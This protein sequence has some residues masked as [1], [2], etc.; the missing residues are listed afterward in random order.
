MANFNSQSQSRHAKT[1]RPMTREHLG[2]LSPQT[3]KIPGMK[4]VLTE[5][6]GKFGVASSAQDAHVA[7]LDY[8][9]GSGKTGMTY[10]SRLGNYVAEF[11]MSYFPY[12]K[13]RKWYVTPGQ[14]TFPANDPGKLHSAEKSRQCILCH[15]VAVPAKSLN[16]DERFLG[17]GCES[18]HGPGSAH[19]AAMRAGKP[20]AS[21]M[22]NIMSQTAT[23]INNLCGT[24]HG[25]E[26]EVKARHLESF[27]NRFQTY[28]LM[29]SE[30]FKQSK[31]TLS[32][33]T[34]HNPHQD[35]GTGHKPYE[36]VCLSCH[37]SPVST[38][39]PAPLKDVAIKPCP[40]NPKENCVSC[41]MPS[42]H[43]IANSKIPTQ[44]ADHFIRVIRDQ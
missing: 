37:A 9:F 28:G 11:H 3:G 44:M 40:V 4:L 34:C 42:R 35:A 39:R 33:V 6:K 1:L 10:V 31:D 16:L 14:E 2:K 30:C 41:H 20:D 8:A 27:S 22:K 5:R 18:C 7:P 12:D 13:K 29:K 36:A 15:A 19:V 24:C 25:T 21:G 26:K 23:G 38:R 17:V 43:A 32:C